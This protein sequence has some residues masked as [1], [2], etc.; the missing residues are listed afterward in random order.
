MAALE[1]A[2]QDNKE[3]FSPSLDGR[4]EPGHDKRGAAMTLRETLK[5]RS[6]RFE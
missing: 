6:G 5:D 1:A 3:F 2:I 4:V